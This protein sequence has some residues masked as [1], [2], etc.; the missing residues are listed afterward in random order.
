MLLFIGALAVVLIIYMVLDNSENKI[1]VKNKTQTAKRS[2]VAAKKGKTKPKE[3]KSGSVVNNTTSKY[4][5]GLLPADVYG[6]M[7]SRG[8][9][10]KKLPETSLG[11]TWISEMSQADFDYEVIAWSEDDDQKVQTIKAIATCESPNNI[12]T[13]VQFF[14]MVSTL[15]YDNSQP[16]RAA[17]WVF[18]NFDRNDASI[19]I[20]GVKFTLIAKSNNEKMLLMENAN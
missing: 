5:A 19:T 17:K 9:K 13:T 12:S 15:P 3:K 8:F 4:I 10:T 7:N 16:Q 11:H 20:S 1:P 6:N 2:K 18:D 14:Q